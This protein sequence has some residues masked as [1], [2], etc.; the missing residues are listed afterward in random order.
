MQSGSFYIPMFLQGMTL[1]SSTQPEHPELLR[2][3]EKGTAVLWLGHL[4]DRFNQPVTSRINLL[5]AHLSHRNDE[6]ACPTKGLRSFG[7]DVRG[8]LIEIRD[9]RAVSDSGA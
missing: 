8:V 3:I 4:E 2:T 5:Y 7:S 9:T 1:A 6:P